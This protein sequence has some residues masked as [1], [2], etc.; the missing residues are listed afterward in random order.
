MHK[1]NHL[2][3]LIPITLQ[4]RIPCCPKQ[5]FHQLTLSSTARFPSSCAP[6]TDEGHCEH[7]VVHG[8][9][10]QDAATEKVLSLPVLSIPDQNNSDPITGS[11]V[12]VWHLDWRNCDGK[13]DLTLSMQTGS[14]PGHYCP[15]SISSSF[16]RFVP[17]CRLVVRSE[18]PLC[19]VG[20]LATR[21]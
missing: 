6:Q 21:A 20:K 19:T 8:P 10:G 13:V 7:T 11:M 3:G 1:K 5:A 17:P 14:G 16:P 12:G 9:H 4:Q 15:I 2:P 18:P